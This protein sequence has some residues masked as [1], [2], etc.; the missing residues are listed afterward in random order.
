MADSFY[1]VLTKAVADVAEHGYDSA[2]RIAGWVKR[3]REAAE[4]RL[5][6]SYLMEGRL[7]EAL[8]AVYRRMVEQ[9]QLSKYH[10]G[11]GRFTLD[12]VR[13]A[14]RA[15]LDR[16][17]MAS[18]NL[19]RLNRE[20][21]IA[22]T[23]R[24]FEGWSTSIPTGGSNTTERRETKQDIR[25]ALAQLPFE[26]RRVLIDQGFKLRSSL[27]EILA[28]DGA[29]IAA[30]WNSHW[31]QANYNYREDHKERDQNIYALRGC[32][33]IEKGL[34]RAGN[35]GYYD[36]ITAAGEEIYCR[37]FITWIYNLRDLP[38]IM[39]T[40]KGRDE[41]ERIRDLLRA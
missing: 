26:E 1:D 18:A 38:T 2:E 31:R 10:P 24:R 5:G 20:E 7:H 36:D 8:N 13:P 41:L 39:L 25:K 27:S 11:V 9:G 19:I 23:L 4:R 40:E 16:R 30:K 21:S 34:M 14:L 35:A 37:C 15:E 6:P 12:K 28:K 32:W 22:K 3:I 33:A 17:I 29:A